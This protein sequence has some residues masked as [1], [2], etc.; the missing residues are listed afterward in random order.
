MINL[1]YTL[2]TI[3]CLCI[4]F[5]FGFKIGKNSEIPDLPK[6]KTPKQIIKEKKEEKQEEEKLNEMNRFLENIDNF[7]NNQKDFN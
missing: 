6:I 3:L 5:Y 7:P 1:I 2:L 4:G